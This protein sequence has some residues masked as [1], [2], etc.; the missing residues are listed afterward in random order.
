MRIPGVPLENL[1]HQRRSISRTRQSRQPLYAEITKTLYKD[2]GYP[3]SVLSLP[4]GRV[5]PRICLAVNCSICS[6]SAR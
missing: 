1:H 4:V 6:R 5:T 2:L 3:I